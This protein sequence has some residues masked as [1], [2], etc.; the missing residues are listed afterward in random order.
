MNEEVRFVDRGQLNGDLVTSTLFGPVVPS[1]SGNRGPSL[2]YPK[3][4][5]IKIIAWSACFAK[6]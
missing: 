6:D 4:Y 2:R 5:S 3:I 1:N